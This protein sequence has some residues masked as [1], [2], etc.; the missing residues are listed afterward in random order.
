MTEA[1]KKYHNSPKGIEAHKNYMKKRNARIKVLLAMYKANGDL[2][3]KVDEAVKKIL[4]TPQVVNKPAP[5]VAPQ[6]TPTNN[7]K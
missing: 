1:Q 6:P 4:A 5:K 2:K 7:K 3:G